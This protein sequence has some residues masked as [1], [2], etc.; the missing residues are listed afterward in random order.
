MAR[1][2]FGMYSE[3]HWTQNQIWINE[4][5]QN[6]VNILDST[7]NDI[8]NRSEILLRIKEFPNSKNVNRLANALRDHKNMNDFRIEIWQPY[9]DIEKITY[10]RKL[11][12]A[13]NYE[14][15]N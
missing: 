14:S 5:N 8:P 7:Y 11:I 1:G 6:I 15:T 3:T 9:M 4:N 2:G 12:K 10:K 13:Y